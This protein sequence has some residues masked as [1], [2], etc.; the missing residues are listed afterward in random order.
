MTV[1]LTRP[2]RKRQKGSFGV[3]VKNQWNF[4]NLILT[5]LTDSCLRHRPRR[6]MSLHL[7]KTMN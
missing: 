6:P 1:P 2:R 7:E 3:V 4:T 5:L